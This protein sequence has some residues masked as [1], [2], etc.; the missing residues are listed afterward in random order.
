MEKS[1]DLR[2][3]IELYFG[4]PKQNIKTYSPLTFAFVG[5]GIY[6]LVIRT[7]IAES[8]NVPVNKLHK[9]TTALVQASAQASLAQMIFDD[10]TQ[11]EQTIYKRGRN[12]KSA[13]SAKNATI[14]DYRKATGL[15]TLVGYL[16]LTGETQRMVELIK[17][18]LDKIETE[19]SL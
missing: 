3:S 14:Q 15:E 10:L 4:Q 9:E 19:R 1:L 5:D 18:G 17:L 16:Y 13:S 6:S 8:G 2:E 11:E 12:T 7:I